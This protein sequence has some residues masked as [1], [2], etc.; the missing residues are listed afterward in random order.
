MNAGALDV[1]RYRPNLSA[2]DLKEILKGR[3]AGRARGSLPPE[4]EAFGSLGRREQFEWLAAVVDL[5]G[6][7]SG[8]KDKPGLMLTRSVASTARCRPRGERSS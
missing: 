1:T 7:A 4:A 5:L 3:L 6:A 8:H 2:L